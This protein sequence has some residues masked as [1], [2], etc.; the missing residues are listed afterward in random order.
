MLIVEAGDG[1]TG[2]HYTVLSTFACVSKL[3]KKLRINIMITLRVSFTHTFFFL[4]FFFLCHFL[5]AKVKTK[6][7]KKPYKNVERYSEL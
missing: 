1:D 6:T 2:I 3:N 7:K 5:L 4:T